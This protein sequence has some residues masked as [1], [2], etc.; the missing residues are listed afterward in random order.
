VIDYAPPVNLVT[1]T[2]ASINVTLNLKNK[3]RELCMADPAAYNYSID[4][5]QAAATQWLQEVAHS[6]K[7]FFLYLSYTV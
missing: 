5:F 1:H 6:S 2:S 7:P 3:S 4:T